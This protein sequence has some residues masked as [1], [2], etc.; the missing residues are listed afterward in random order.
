MPYLKTA[1]TDTLTLP[2]DQAY[3]VTMKARASYGD[4]ENARSAML[5]IGTPTVAG[6]APA[7]SI[8]YKAYVA[9]LT[10]SLIT[11]WNLTDETD[12]PLPVTAASLAR[13]DPVDG[14]FLAAEAQK[15]AAPRPEVRE[16]PF[17]STSTSS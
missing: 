5:K 13:L 11:A 8:E 9:A 12:A 17:G 10:L 1:S 4:V 14:D 3:N 16:I 7:A 6:A 15:R 2:S